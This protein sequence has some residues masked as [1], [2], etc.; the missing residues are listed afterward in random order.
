M[1]FYFHIQI[2][3]NFIVY[4]LDYLKIAR[5]DLR[6][7]CFSMTFVYINMVVIGNESKTIKLLYKDD[8]I[9]VI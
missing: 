2:L 1:L 5:V 6:E 3:K 4:V 8:Q 9:I 7:Y